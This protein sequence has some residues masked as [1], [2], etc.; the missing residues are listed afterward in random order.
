MIDK[1]GINQGAKPDGFISLAGAINQNREQVVENHKT[2]LNA[3]LAMMLG[4]LDFDK[5]FVKAEGVYVWDST[6]EKYLDFLGAY[7]ALNTG[8]NHPRILEALDQVRELPN[9][10]QASLGTVVSALAKN[11]ALITPGELQRSFFCNSGAEAVEGALKLAR[12][13]TGRRS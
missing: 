3:S 6:G 5:Q 1:P 12:A 8:H 10:L 9:L 13:A 2:Y 4:L 7:G 11:M